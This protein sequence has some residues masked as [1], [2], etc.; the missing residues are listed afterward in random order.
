MIPPGA[1]PPGATSTDILTEGIAVSA[2]VSSSRRHA[3]PGIVDSSKLL[4]MEPSVGT[5]ALLGLRVEIAP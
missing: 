5:E 2:R 4:P 3:V 1:N